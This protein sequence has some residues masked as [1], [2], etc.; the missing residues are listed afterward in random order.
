MFQ[1]S[2]LYMYEYINTYI[3]YILYA[4]TKG[5][6]VQCLPLLYGNV[7]MERIYTLV[8]SSHDSATF[9]IRVPTCPAI[10][11]RRKSRLVQFTGGSI[12][13]NSRMNICPYVHSSSSLYYTH[14]NYN[15]KLIELRDL[16]IKK[17]YSKKYI[18]TR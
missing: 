12:N 1:A 3:L 7:Y 10:T 15:S 2:I 9:S 17:K 14:I 13:F 8:A 5:V 11:N 6:K 18:Y 4:D 16:K